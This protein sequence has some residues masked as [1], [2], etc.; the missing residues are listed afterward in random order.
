MPL[1]ATF[2][3]D[4]SSFLDAT[5]KS[6][7]ATHELTTAAQGVGPAFNGMVTETSKAAEAQ[8]KQ[9][10][11][12]AARQLE[13]GRALGENFKELASVTV[14]FGKTYIDAFAQSEQA[15]LRLNKAL[16]DAGNAQAA[17]TYADLA[18]S[19]AK[20]STFSKPALV[21][22]ETLLTTVGNVKPDNMKQALQAT[23]DLAA[24]MAG[25]GMSLEQAA[26]LVAKAASSDGEALGKLKVIL[27][28][29]APKG[30]DFAVVMDAINKKFGGEAL[31]NLESTAG[32][33]ERLKNQM[34]EVNDKIGSVLAPTLT[35]MLDLFQ[36]LPDG[37]QTFVIAIGSIGTAVAP[38][39]ISLSS[40]AAL[41]STELGAAAMAAVGAA[42]GS[43]AAPL[44][45]AGAAVLA[46]FEI[47]KHWKDQPPI[48]DQALMA[49]QPGLE[50]WPKLLK[51]IGDAAI[52][53]FNTIKTWLYDKMSYLLA[54][55]ESMIGS[56]AQ[57][58]VAWFQWMY[59]T[60]V[61][62]SIIPD[63]MTGIA[64]EFSKLDRVMVAPALAAINTVAGAFGDFAST[65]NVLGN[66]SQMFNSI[67]AGQSSLYNPW[68]ILPTAV[69]ALDGAT[70]GGSQITIN[71][72]GMLG[73]D[74]P[75][76]RAAMRDLISAAL[77]P[78]MRSTRLLGST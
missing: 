48:L 75:Q 60:L 34:E 51:P 58:I 25:S 15:T 53:V 26:K 20:L 9:Q 12:Q 32:Q 38:V 63:M 56:A 41:L 76:T 16:Q 69:P 57:T 66:Q 17:S 54:Q 22:V 23:M 55:T 27:G 47:W 52:D 67:M 5:R 31:T 59:H 3:A 44:A 42:I 28:D 4:F 7:D 73:T 37:V 29:A 77:M 33:M 64:N 19:M 35:K 14:E 72:T 11:D 36:K 68:P 39:L 62:G 10:S 46:L 13:F 61:G 8:A 49:I 70:M 65:S 21:D 6:V 45:V 40:L 30:S 43:I 50:L 1:T 18:E 71:M 74:D 24:G 2:V 78:G